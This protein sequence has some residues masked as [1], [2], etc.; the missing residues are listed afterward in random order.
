MLS[1]RG[2]APALTFA[3]TTRLDGSPSRSCGVPTNLLDAMGPIDAM[4]SAF[5]LDAAAYVNP[6]PDVD[7]FLPD[8]GPDNAYWRCMKDKDALRM[9]VVGF[10]ENGTMVQVWVATG[11]SVS[12][13]RVED[14]R[15]II[16]HLR[17]GR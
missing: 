1:I 13:A 7:A 17:V 11:L 12:E 3:T 14:I 6:R 16:R 8:S 10:H 5:P 15:T 9:K 4:I 2:P